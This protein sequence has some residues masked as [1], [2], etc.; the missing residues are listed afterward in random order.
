MGDTSELK[1]SMN[2]ELVQDQ[3][4]ARSSQVHSSLTRNSGHS[5]TNNLLAMNGKLGGQN[6]LTLA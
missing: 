2:P 1:L 3:K 5:G 4:K 6:G